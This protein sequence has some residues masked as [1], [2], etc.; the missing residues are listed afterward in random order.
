[1]NRIGTASITTLFLPMLL[2]AQQPRVT[3]QVSGPDPTTNSFRFMAEHYG[4][5]LQQAFDSI[6]GDKY[7]YRPMPAQQSIGYIAQHL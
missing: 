4:P 1:M 2:H 5:W 6:P 7:A 3:P